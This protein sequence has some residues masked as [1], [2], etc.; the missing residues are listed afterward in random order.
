LEPSSPA[1][2]DTDCHSDEI[3]NRQADFLPPDASAIIVADT[4]LRGAFVCTVSRPNG[5]FDSFHCANI[6][7]H[8]SSNGQRDYNVPDPAADAFAVA[9]PI[10]RA[11]APAVSRADAPAVACSKQSSSTSANSDSDI[12]AYAIAIF[13]AGVSADSTAD[14]P[15]VGHSQF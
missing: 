10:S 6:G 4:T 11:D 5:N 15:A 7:P 3:A 1:V 12:E 13:T 8:A 2:A 14:A 9:C